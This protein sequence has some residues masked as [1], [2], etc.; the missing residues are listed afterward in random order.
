RSSHRAIASGLAPFL[1]SS[2][3]WY[4]RRASSSASSA[5]SRS[6]SAIA[7]SNEPPPKSFLKNDT[8]RF[9]CPWPSGLLAVALGKPPVGRRAERRLHVLAPRQRAQVVEA[10]VAQEA[11]R[12]A[13]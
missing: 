4:A 2:A 10:K 1:R 5:K 7:S 11:H 6:P 3:R 9:S 13:H 12:D 8:A